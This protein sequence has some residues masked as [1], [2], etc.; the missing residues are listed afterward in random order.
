MKTVDREDCKIY[1][2]LSMRGTTI[3]NLGHLSNIMLA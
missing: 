3:Y 2:K 1:A